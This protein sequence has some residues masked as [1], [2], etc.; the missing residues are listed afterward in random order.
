MF[1]NYRS[2]ANENVSQGT[3]RGFLSEQT[4]AQKA[5]SVY[6]HMSRFERYKTITVDPGLSSLDHFSMVETF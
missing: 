4:H 1:V 2:G 5:L 6:T 3:E